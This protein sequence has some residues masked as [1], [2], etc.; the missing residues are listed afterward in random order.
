[1][2]ALA[3]HRPTGLDAKARI[4]ALAK[5]TTAELRKELADA[6]DLTAGYLNY[7]GA[8]WGEL[9]RRGEDLSELRKGM[10]F[11]LSKI[12]AGQLL[13]ETV[14]K[15]AGEPGIL[16]RMGACSLDKQRLALD[17]GKLPWGERRPRTRPK[18]S[19]PNHE[20]VNHVDGTRESADPATPAP[21]GVHLD[22][23]TPVD[24]ALYELIRLKHAYGH[25]PE[26]REVFAAFDRITEARERF[27][28]EDQ[29]LRK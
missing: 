16:R 20:R 1:V 9:T 4:Q 15:Y 11:Y 24:E 21:N 26:L 3:T 23:R 25:L 27:R 6:L 13:A 12:A 7:L 19:G 18:W 10:G 22:L 29:R 2:T 5:A 28:A 8:V 17:S 14:V